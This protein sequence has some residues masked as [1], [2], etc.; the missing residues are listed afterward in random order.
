MFNKQKDLKIQVPLKTLYGSKYLLSLINLALIGIVVILGITITVLYFFAPGMDILKD[1]KEANSL[2]NEN[3]VAD[4]KSIESI[5]S[6]GKNKQSEDY[7]IIS[8]KNI[9]SAQRKEWDVV[10]SKTSPSDAFKKKTPM[11]KKA[12]KKP[13]KFLLYGVIIAGDIKKALVNN[14]S[15]GRGRKKAVY[16]EEG[17]EIEGCKVVSIEADQITLDW[18]GEEIIVGLYSGQ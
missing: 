10:A 15:K 11:K 2:D 16:I 7:S 6:E 1:S 5:F 18:Q 4:T 12:P 13:T 3:I 8:T 14:T 17:D 9:F